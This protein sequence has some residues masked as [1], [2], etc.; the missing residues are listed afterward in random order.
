MFNAIFVAETTYHIR[1]AVNLANINNFLLQTTN[2]DRRPKQKTED[3]EDDDEDDKPLVPT[4]QSTKQFS[5]NSKKSNEKENKVAKQ[6]KAI[7]D[8]E[9]D[10]ELCPEEILGEC[11]NSGQQMLLMQWKSADK[12]E[13][14]PLQEAI[15]KCTE[16]SMSSTC[17]NESFIY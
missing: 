11:H 3:N 9:S 8:D 5:S 14:V 1:K 4:S 13:L 17:W 16:I 10:D 7:K 12:A 2:H 15:V 6:V